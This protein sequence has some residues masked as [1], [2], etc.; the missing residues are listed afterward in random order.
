MAERFDRNMCSKWSCSGLRITQM[1]I[2]RRER[3]ARA[4][5]A[6]IDRAATGA[7]EV[8]LCGLHQLAAQSPTLPRGSDAQ[9]PEITAFA[10]ELHVNAS[11][12]AG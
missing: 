5:D 8:I 2:K 9:Q 4:N 1:S 6:Q 11:R 3:S 12:Q 7:A 10:P